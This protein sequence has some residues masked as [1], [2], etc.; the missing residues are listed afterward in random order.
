MGAI[1]KEIDSKSTRGQKNKAKLVQNSVKTRFQSPFQVRQVSERRRTFGRG[2]RRG[3]GGG[4]GGRGVVFGIFGAGGGGGGG[5]DV[6]VDVGA[7]VEV[8]VEGQGGQHQVLDEEAALDARGAG[9]RR[10]L[11]PLLQHVAQPAP[12]TAT[13]TTTTT[14]TSLDRHRS[15]EKRLYVH[16]VDF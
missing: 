3:V 2:Q 10:R 11:A 12:T 16:A 4:V 15:I 7:G 8:E 13:A 14:T 9:R 1:R 5:G 6:V